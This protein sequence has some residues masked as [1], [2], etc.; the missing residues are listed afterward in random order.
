MWSRVVAVVAGAAIAAG[1]FAL[2]R[3]TAD[4]HAG[5]DAGVREGRAAGL[6]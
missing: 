4:T 5:H 2:G 6:Q 1:A 3:T